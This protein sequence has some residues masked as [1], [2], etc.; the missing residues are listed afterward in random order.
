MRQTRDRIRHAV[1]FELIALILSIPLGNLIFGVEPAHFGVVAL[2]S[3][4]IA[5]GWTYLFNLGFD[6]AALRLR[7]T[8]AKTPVL[9]IVHVVLFEAGLLVLLVPFIAWYLRIPLARAFMM[10][11]SLTGFY[12]AYA[13]A[14]NWA[15]DLVFP[16]EP[17]KRPA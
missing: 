7:G 15:Y 8:P 2:V 1:L 13:L 17:D 16:V 11:L 14:F 3:S 9:R 5:M 4:T 10:D 6:H 12:A